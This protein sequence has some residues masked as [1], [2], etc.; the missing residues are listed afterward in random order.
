M[1]AIITSRETPLLDPEV[2][3]CEVSCLKFIKKIIY[4]GRDVS[5]RGPLLCQFWTAFGV[6]IR[7]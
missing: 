5:S 3:S 2:T 6:L 7:T 1:G 4:L